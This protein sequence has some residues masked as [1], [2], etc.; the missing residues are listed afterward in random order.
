MKC[1]RRTVAHS[2]ATLAVIAAASGCAPANVDP[3]QVGTSVEALRVEVGRR[4]VAYDYGSRNTLTHGIAGDERLVFV[5]EPLASRV[6][7]LDRITGSEIAVLPA[8]AGGM[9]L[10][11]TLRVSRTGRLVVMDAGGFPNPSIPSVARVY[12]YDYSYNPT[13]RAFSATVARTVRFDGLPLVFAEDL[14]VLP[15]GTYVLAESVIGALWLI[16]PNGTIAP[17]L[18]PDSL[19]P[20]A[21]IPQIGPCQFNSTVTADG[22]P[23]AS[24]GDFAPG[25]GSVAARGNTLYFSGTCQGALYRIPIASLSDPS[26]SPQQRAADITLV[27][28]MPAD[29][30]GAVLKG[31]AVNRFDPSDNRIY[32]LES[33]A[34]R[35]VRIDPNTGVRTVLVRDPV[36]FNFPVAAAFLPPVLGLTPLVVSSDQEHRFAGINAG[37]TVDQ[38][39]PPWV[40]AKVYVLR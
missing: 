11:F 17:G 13:T 2:F 24:A 18:F 10:P 36:L 34:M 35:V 30:A 26:R 39:T 28:P 16:R 19:A 33:A 14:E 6:V 5:T 32:A 29:P 22:I 1:L 37:I 12:D 4:A 27:S 9:V 25:V 20:G 23:F 40:L 15:D 38:F 31:L 21:G 3:E 7:V 8:P